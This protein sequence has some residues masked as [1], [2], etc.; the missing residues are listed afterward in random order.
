MFVRD[1]MKESVHTC[2]AGESLECAARV[3]WEHDCG[4]VPIVDDAQ[5]VVGVITDRDVAMAAY[6]QGKPLPEIPI[7]GI[8]ARDVVTC[9]PSD[10]LDLVEDLLQE[11]QIRR[12]PVVDDGGRLVGILSLNDLVRGATPGGRL[13]AP[14]PSEIVSTLAAIGKP[15]IIH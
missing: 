9:H 13:G 1:L 8:M 10:P 2:H 14:V 15:R 11:A 12:V 5:R 7:G 6:T 4:V 3:M